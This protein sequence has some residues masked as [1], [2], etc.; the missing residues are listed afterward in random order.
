[1]SKREDKRREEQAAAREADELREAEAAEQGEAGD[2]GEQAAEAE[3]RVEQDLEALG[4]LQKERDEFEQRLLRTAADFQNYV[5]RAEL[6]VAAAREQTVMELAKALVTVVDHFDRALEVD[7]EK[8]TTQ[9]VLSGVQMVRDELL[10]AL[11]RWGVERLEVKRGEAFDP[12]R[13]EALM[14]Q[15]D[16]EVEADHV[17]M[18]LQ[19]GYLIGEKTIRPAKVSLAE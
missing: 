4:K 1:M 9:D 18:Q 3:E 13:H 15:A 5:R 16:A 19:P 7:P 8:A 12:N 11:G 10:R 14:R 2:V 6:N 17:T